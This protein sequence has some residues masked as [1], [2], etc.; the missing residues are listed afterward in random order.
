M[1]A[2]AV[3]V[4]SLIVFTAGLLRG[5][6]PVQMLLTAVSLAV[7]AVPEALPAVVTLTLAQGDL[8][9]GQA[10]GPSPADCPLWRRWVRSLTSAR[11]RPGR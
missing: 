8:D 10:S 7:A 6:D 3:V 9:H 1:I 2:V 11:T 4:I 5:E